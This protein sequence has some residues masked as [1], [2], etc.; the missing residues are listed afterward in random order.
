MKKIYNKIIRITKGRFE[1]IFTFWFIF[2]TL[3]AVFVWMIEAVLG[4]SHLP[5]WYDLSYFIFCVYGYIK[6]LSR[7]EEVI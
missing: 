7:L 4:T 3:I 6:T 5:Q 2:F 1:R